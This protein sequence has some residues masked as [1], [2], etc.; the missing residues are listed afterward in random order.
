MNVTNF[1]QQEK[2]GLF[3]VYLVGVK[4]RKKSQK[5]RKESLTLSESLTFQG[6]SEVFLLENMAD[7]I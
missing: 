4:T 5:S 6:L 3:L 7:A 1:S 2:T